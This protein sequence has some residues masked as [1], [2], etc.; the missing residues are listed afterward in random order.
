[1]LANGAL[2]S[3]APARSA[4]IG[5]QITTEITTL[6][7]IQKRDGDFQL[8]ARGFVSREDRIV[9]VG[10]DLEVFFGREQYVRFLGVYHAH[11]AQ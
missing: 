4:R 8:H 9:T 11:K 5:P 10:G 2:R 1:M 6:P 7:H 3:A